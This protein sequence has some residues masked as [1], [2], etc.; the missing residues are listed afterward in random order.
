MLNPARV[1]RV[2]VWLVAA[3]VA[4]PVLAADEKKSDAEKPTTEKKADAPKPDA[5]PDEKKSDEKKA[6]ETKAEPPD[7][8]AV[9]DGTPK[10]L[11]QYINGL[12]RIR[13]TEAEDR[14]KMFEAIL[15]AAEKIM[16]AKP[17]DTELETAVGLKSRMLR[18]LGKADALPD[19]ADQLKKDGHD[20]LARNV[21]GVIK[22][23]E[24][25]AAASKG[26]EAIKKSVADIVKFL[27]E[28]PPRVSDLGLANIAGRV[29][30]MSKDRQFSLSTYRALAK[31]FS[32]SDDA[33]MSKFSKTLEGVVRRL[34]LVGNAMKVEGK[35][36]GGEEFDWSK[37]LGKVVL[38]DFWATWCPPCVAEVP[39]MKEIYAAYHEKGFDIVGVSVDRK[40]TDLETFIK[41]KEIP[42]TI[43]YAGD[44]KPTVTAD[45]YGIMVIPTMILVGK[46]GKVISIEARGENLRNELEKLFGPMPEKKKDDKKD[47]AKDEKKGEDGAAK[48]NGN[49]A[50]E[51]EK[52]PAEAKP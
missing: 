8:Y 11:M 13:P 37:Q 26:P 20:K 39:N 35:T 6:D 34:D 21:Q 45:Y 22:Q 17:T 14:K 42:W 2:F 36:V 12:N 23:G 25:I 19:F 33:M 10:E 47:D 16:A 28:S 49:D 18:A 30:E 43:L 50:K 3:A 48:D 51:S 40:Q 38:V 7:P 24:L 9:P 31:H 46:D 29:A 44:D 52:K 5:A 15:K 41:D 1:L 32:A 27:E 4:W